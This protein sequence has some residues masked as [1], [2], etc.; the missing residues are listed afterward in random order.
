MKISLFSKQNK[1]KKHAP[2]SPFILSVRK[3]FTKKKKQ[4]K[5]GKYRKKSHT[6]TQAKQPSCTCYPP[7]KKKKKQ[8]KQTCVKQKTLKISKKGN[9]DESTS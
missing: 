3:S 5:H 8:N 2:S 9:A 7:V 6:H 1:T 4:L